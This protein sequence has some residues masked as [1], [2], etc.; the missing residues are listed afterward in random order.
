VILADTGIWI[1]HI[2]IADPRLYALLE[3]GQVL[4]HPMVI[5]ELSMGSFRSRQEMLAD[6]EKLPKVQVGF[7]SDVLAFVDRHRLYGTG[8]GYIDAHLLV[9]ARLT[10]HTKLWTRDRRLRVAAARFELADKE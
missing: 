7:H 5:G 2:A 10:P 9:A 3:R 4:I 8:I 1:D 6:L